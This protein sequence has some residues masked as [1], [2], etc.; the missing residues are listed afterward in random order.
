MTQEPV[1]G[2]VFSI[3]AGEFVAGVPR[4][5]TFVET[6]IRSLADLG[7]S[8]T[9]SVVDDRTSLSGI[10][11]NVRRL[12]A[13]VARSEAEIVHA[14]Y[15]SV[16]A[17]VAD[18]ARG[19]LP[20]V[21]S[22]CGDD[23]LGTP[24]PGLL[25]RLRARTSRSVGLLA[26]WRAQSL[27]V[28]SRNLLDALPDPLRRRTEVIPSGVDEQIFLPLD[29]SEARARLGWS[30]SQP[31]V[32]FNAGTSPH[33]RVKNPSLAHATMAMLHESHPE[34][35]LETLS[36]TPHAEVPLKMNAADCMLVTSLHEGSPNIVKEAMACN[37]QWS[38][39]PAAMSPSGSSVCDRDASLPTT[40][41]NWPP[42]FGTYSSGVGAPMDALSWLTR[43]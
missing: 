11:R 34:A 5:W 30:Q 13:E 40:R 18:A 16:T 38:V 27:V 9:L 31:V 37:L 29:R 20:L 39:F 19:T 3:S 36:S 33:T 28:K 24:E 4:S 42:A 12:R 1:P 35:R 10:A 23:L 2:N 43:D 6:Q 22:F 21:I 8:V 26:A 25:W 7:W 41:L 17:A 32:L 15:G 14:Q